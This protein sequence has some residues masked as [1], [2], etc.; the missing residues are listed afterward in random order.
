LSWPASCA[1]ACTGRSPQ[2]RL[3]TPPAAADLATINAWS[4]QPLAGPTLGLVDGRLL[5]ERTFPGTHGLLVVLAR[6]GVEILTGPL[7][8]RVRECGREDCALLFIDETRAATRRWCSMSTCGARSKMS[9]YR[10]RKDHGA[11]P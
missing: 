8:G 4:A 5:R 2:V 9:A 10:S 1:K 3:G 11:A 6:D 7:S